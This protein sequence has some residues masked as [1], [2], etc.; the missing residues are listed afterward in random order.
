MSNDELN[1]NVET[2]NGRGGRIAPFVIRASTFLRHSSFVLRH[3]ND[4]VCIRVHSS[5]K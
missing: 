4:L 5:L 3:F 1:P 2:R